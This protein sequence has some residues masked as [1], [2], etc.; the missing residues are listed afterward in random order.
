MKRILLLLSLFILRPG[1]GQMRII[2]AGS[3]I[4]EIV[5]ALGDG[6]KIVASDRTSLYPAFIQKLPSIGYRSGINAEG[7]I[8]LSPTLILAEKEYVD[9]SVIEHLS[10]SKI[11][12]VVVEKRASFEDT[13]KTISQIAV[14]LDRIAEGK[15]MIANIE[16]A[17]EEVRAM[18]PKT[19]NSPRVLC[20]YNRGAASISV[21]GSTTF[22]E[23]LKY[24]GATNAVT[25]VDGYKPLN[26]ES[27]IAADPEYILMLSSGFDS[28]GGIDGVLKIPG[29]AQ[30][31]AG[32]KKQIISMESLKLTNFGP[33]LGEAVKELVVLVHPELDVK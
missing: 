14:A 28:I 30:T 26:T 2:T 23:I 13:K 20:V 29:V 6:D 16:I 15:Q 10:S 3:A 5:C 19:K 25:G 4:T 11:K 18:L 21:A 7:I 8:S 1:Y 31:T 33:R 32:K 22:S 12:L 17:L 27:L 24:V 9:A